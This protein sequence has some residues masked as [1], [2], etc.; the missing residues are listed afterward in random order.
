MAYKE[1]H[2]GSIYKSQ[3][4]TEDDAFSEVYAIECNIDEDKEE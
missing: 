2:H 4:M 1:N 3:G